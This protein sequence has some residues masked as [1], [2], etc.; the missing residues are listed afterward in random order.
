MQLASALQSTISLVQ[1]FPPALIPASCAWPMV[2]HGAPSLGKLH[3]Q[4]QPENPAQR[5]GHTT[6]D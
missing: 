1:A 5:L 4:R 3:S 2:L 6:I